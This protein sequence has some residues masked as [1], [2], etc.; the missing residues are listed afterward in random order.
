[1]IHRR[2]QESRGF[3]HT[4]ITARSEEIMRKK[5]FRMSLGLLSLAAA[6]TVAPKSA[7]AL[8]GCP[9]DQ[10]IGGV[11]CTWWG[12]LDCALCEYNCQGLI[13]GPVVECGT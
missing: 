3:A 10:W 11:D 9:S 4:I 6:L 12:G 2:A 1:V 7:M 8:D 13:V 5:L